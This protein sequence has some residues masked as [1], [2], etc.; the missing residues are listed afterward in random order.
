MAK[1]RKKR[2]RKKSNEV[3]SLI[4]ALGPGVVLLKRRK[5]GVHKDKRRGTR[6]EE[7]EDVEKLFDDEAD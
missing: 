7:S 1:K 2:Q 3:K 5:A 4:G 6:G